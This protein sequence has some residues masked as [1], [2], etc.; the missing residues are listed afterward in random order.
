MTGRYG[1]FTGL[2]SGR[3]LCSPIRRRPQPV[4]GLV[5]VVGEAT[6]DCNELC[7]P[8]STCI[9]S[10]L[11]RL[12]RAYHG[13]P[14]NSD[15]VQ[16]VET[17]VDRDGSTS[18]GSSRR[19]PLHVAQELQTLSH[20]KKFLVLYCVGFIISCQRGSQWPAQMFVS[21]ARSQIVSRL[22]WTSA[23]DDITHRD[24]QERSLGLAAA[25]RKPTGKSKVRLRLRLLRP[26]GVP[27]ELAARK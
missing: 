24:C 7:C 12:K 10:L 1:L 20:A 16:T 3:D 13:G 4:V 21:V 25:G 15:K 26:S 5:A 11:S 23:Y 9:L 14:L 19:G 27:D 17:S 8:C 2:L 22:Q 6:D 18:L